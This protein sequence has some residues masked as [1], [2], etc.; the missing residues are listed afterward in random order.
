[1]LRRSFFTRLLVSVAGLL[2]LG[3]A[4]RPAVA[5]LPEPMPLQLDHDPKQYYV[6]SGKCFG[7]DPIAFS[8]L[9]NTGTEDF[10]IRNAEGR[11]L[12]RIA[13]GGQLWVEHDAEIYVA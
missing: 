6:Q 8:R 5:T 3:A 13:P 11:E 7:C 10:V 4:A 1:M 12:L 2:G 9:A